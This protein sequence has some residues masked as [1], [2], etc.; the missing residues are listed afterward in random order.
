MSSLLASAR[1]RAARPLGSLPRPRLTV[2]S[3]VTPRAPRVPFVVLVMTVLVAGLV[4]LLLLNTALQ[5]GAYTATALRQQSSALAVHQQ[6]LEVQVAALRQ[7]QRVAVEAQRLGMVTN[8]S[9]V[10]L[11]LATGKIIGTPVA[12]SRANQVDVSHLP[13]VHAA[14]H[15]AKVT[16]PAAGAAN[17]LGTGP[18]TVADPT[19]G[20]GKPS[21]QSG[22]GNQT[23][24]DPAGGGNGGAQG[25][26][27]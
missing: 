12:G 24:Q 11:S 16:T 15:S 26:H 10:F 4:G 18:I 19:A 13:T 8:D 7:P 20:H 22:H 5:R 6:E 17:S 1:S 14:A 23:A 21:G 3:K 27:Q 25:G 9:P 2:V